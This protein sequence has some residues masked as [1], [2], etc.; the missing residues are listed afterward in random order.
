MIALAVLGGGLTT[1]GTAALLARR[2]YRRPQRAVVVIVF[3]GAI[4]SL[5]WLGPDLLAL[6]FVLWGLYF[7]E[8]HRLGF[9]V[10]LFAAAA[11]T[12]EVTLL[13]PAALALHALVIER[14]FRRAVIIALPALALVAW[15]LVVHARLGYFP[16]DAGVARLAPPWS[17]MVKAVDNWSVGD[18]VLSMANY[19]LLIIV[20]KRPR[21]A[22]SWVIGAVLL[23]S[24]VLGWNVWEQWRHVGRVFLLAQVLALVMVLTWS[25]VPR[26]PPVRSG[27]PVADRGPAG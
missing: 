14:S 24:L 19:L 13:V 1:S 10:G 18:V 16:W 21:D 27:A 22:Y 8:Q 4:M 23:F 15:L 6:G 9:A 11:L 2:G 3:P 25:V 5:S 17:G 26:P 12:R 20:V 7:L